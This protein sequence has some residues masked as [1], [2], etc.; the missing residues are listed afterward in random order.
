MD[1]AK[2]N[3]GPPWCVWETQS[4]ATLASIR[5]QNTFCARFRQMPNFTFRVPWPLPIQEILAFVSRPIGESARI[6]VPSNEEMRW[7]ACVVAVVAGCYIIWVCHKIYSVVKN[8]YILSLFYFLLDDRWHNFGCFGWILFL[9]VGL[10]DAFFEMTVWCH[11][12]LLLPA[13]N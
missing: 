8:R 3:S 12:V 6:L 4:I 13:T 9:M 7:V 5:I 11:A 10:L 1:T 2:R